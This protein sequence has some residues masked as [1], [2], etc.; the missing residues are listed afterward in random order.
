VSIRAPDA[1][2]DLYTSIANQLAVEIPA[3]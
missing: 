3:G 2:I 1:E